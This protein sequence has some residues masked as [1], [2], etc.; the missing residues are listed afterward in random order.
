MT[1]I[2]K[3]DNSN[4]ILRILGAQLRGLA[5][6]RPRAVVPPAQRVRR[7]LRAL[8]EAQQR[9]LAPR[10]RG[11]P[12]LDGG[13]HGRH[14]LALGRAV[15]GEGG[16]VDDGLDGGVGDRGRDVVGD[17]ADAAGARLLACC[18]RDDHVQAVCAV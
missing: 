14:A 12:V 13:R 5:K 18:A 7:D 10:A 6:R 9:D 15:V 16:R 8:R 3:H 1:R 2:T 4:N 11:H 17:D